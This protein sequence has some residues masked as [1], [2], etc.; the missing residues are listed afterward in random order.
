MPLQALVRVVIPRY[1]D[2]VR[3]EMSITLSWAASAALQVTSLTVISLEIWCDVTSLTFAGTGEGGHLMRLFLWNCHISAGRIAPCKAYG[4][5]KWPGR[6]RSRSIGVISGTI[7]D[8]LF[9]EIVLSATC[10]LWLE[11]RCYAEHDHIWRLT[12]SRDLPKIIWRHGSWL[13]TCSSKIGNF[14][15]FLRSWDRICDS[16]FSHR[17]VY[18]AY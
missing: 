10:C 18:R 16:F 2:P 11:W 6:V 1:L 12:L 13:S 17:L 3:P 4:A 9:T 7:T 15:D 5:K 8:E 14:G